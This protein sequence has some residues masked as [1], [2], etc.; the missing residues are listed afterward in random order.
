MSLKQP[1]QTNIV[2]LFCSRVLV[3]CSTSQR[4]VNLFFQIKLFKYP[5]LKSLLYIPEKNLLSNKWFFMEID[6]HESGFCRLHTDRR[7][8][9][10]AHKEYHLF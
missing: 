8:Q 4:P 3:S 9:I 5:T 6:I 7:M 1:N 10:E 2:D